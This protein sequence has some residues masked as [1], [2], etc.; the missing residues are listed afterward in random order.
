MV[1][2]KSIMTKKVVTL[3]SSAFVVTAAKAMT[4]NKVSCV[5]V[6][7][8]G[9]PIGMVTERDIT[10]KLVAKGKLASGV[11]VNTIMT[12][13]LR[14]IDVDSDFM[15]ASTILKKYKIRR[16]PVLKAERLVG[17]VTQTDLLQASIHFIDGIADK[18]SS[19]VDNI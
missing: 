19:V 3:A 13:P 4:K 11:R 14:T 10:R 8:R 15:K 12:T 16:L 7:E 6:T 1:T 17:I 18:I 2:I 9:I 5:I